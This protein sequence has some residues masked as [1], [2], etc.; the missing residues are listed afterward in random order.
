MLF[1]SLV[2]FVYLD[3]V[4]FLA[5]LAV[6]PAI[7]EFLICR[8]VVSMTILEVAFLAF[9]SVNVRLLNRKSVVLG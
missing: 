9:L 2:V 7:I 4:K 1:D 3:S 6:C 5:N 8:R